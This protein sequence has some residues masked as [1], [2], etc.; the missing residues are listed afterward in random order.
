VF[1]S[2]WTSIAALQRVGFSARLWG[3]LTL[4]AL[5]LRSL[6]DEHREM[7]KHGAER[8][9]CAGGMRTDVVTLLQVRD[10]CTYSIVYRSVTKGPAAK[11]DEDSPAAKEAREALIA[12][13]TALKAVDAVLESGEKGS[14]DAKAAL[15]PA[16]TKVCARCPP[17][18]GRGGVRS[19]QRLG[20]FAVRHVRALHCHH[21]LPYALALRLC[22]PLRELSVG[23]DLLMLGLGWRL[24]RQ[25]AFNTVMTVTP[26]RLRSS[27][28]SGARC[29]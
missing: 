26:S 6:V 24:G 9:E 18:G 3:F 13:I 16:F 22:S 29:G 19:A 4:V 2:T 15:T 5:L 27:Y 17:V 12:L 11:N 23:A 1:D 28:P 7:R 10:V 25:T 14:A 20:R 21:W 8:T